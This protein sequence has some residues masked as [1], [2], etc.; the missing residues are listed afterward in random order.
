MKK[1]KSLERVEV[2]FDIDHDVGT[3]EKI[4][5]RKSHIEFL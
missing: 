4:I 1:I 3:F 2:W 5:G